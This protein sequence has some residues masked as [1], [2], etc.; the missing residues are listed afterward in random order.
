MKIPPQE[1]MRSEPGG[2]DGGAGREGRV[3]DSRGVDCGGTPN[4]AYGYDENA[5][6]SSTRKVI[7]EY[8]N[9]IIVALVLAAFVMTFVARSFLVQ[10]SSMEPT[11]HHGERLLVN[12][13]V[14][15]FS[16]P[17]RGDIVVFRYPENPRQMF[18][19]R[20]IGVPGDV[21]EITG[22]VVYVSGMGLV[23]PYI[24]E[25]PMGEYG[26]ALVPA[27]RVFVLGDNRNSS[28]DS[29]HESV[30]MVPYS[31]IQG[32]AFLVYW[33]FSQLRTCKNPSYSGVPD[34]PGSYMAIVPGTL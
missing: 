17:R 33:P 12:R 18:I 27:N 4:E 11:L 15:R 32:K 23:E 13:F 10:G 6:V 25:P 16:E 28:H 26:P 34:H 21:V 24:A 20:V 22:G 29:T 7:L 3:A 30:G 5:G 31:S 19:K 14:Y 2:N 9:T 8:A 1:K